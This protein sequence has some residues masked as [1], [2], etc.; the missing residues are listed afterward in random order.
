MKIRIY[1]TILI[2]CTLYICYSTCIKNTCFKKKTNKPSKQEAYRTHCLPEYW[3]L[4]IHKHD[5]TYRFTYTF[6]KKCQCILYIIAI[7]SL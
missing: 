4:A 6:Y 2:I 5:Q 3:F 1:K 7:I